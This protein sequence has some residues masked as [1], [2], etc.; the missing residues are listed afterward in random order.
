MTQKSGINEDEMMTL[1]HQDLTERIIGAANYEYADAS[2]RAAK[3]T[4]EA[5]RVIAS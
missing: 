5:K 4:I 1:E 3:I 2:D